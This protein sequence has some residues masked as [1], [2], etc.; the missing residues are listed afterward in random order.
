MKLCNEYVVSVCVCVCVCVCVWK[1]W[2]CVEWCVIVM[3]LCVIVFVCVRVL[4]EQ[5]EE[6]ERRARTLKEKR[7]LSVCM[8]V[9]MCVGGR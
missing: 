1:L 7:E 8:Y 3:C 6:S 5:R 4:R 9:C 2:L